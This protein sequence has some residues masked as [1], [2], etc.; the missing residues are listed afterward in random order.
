MQ[1]WKYVEKKTLEKVISINLNS[2]HFVYQVYS[3]VEYVNTGYLFTVVFYVEQHRKC[4]G[5]K[6][7]PILILWTLPG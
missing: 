4:L 1:M 7:K 2:E 6:N 5:P 3:T